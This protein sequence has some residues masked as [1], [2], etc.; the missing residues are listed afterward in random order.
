MPRASAKQ[1]I[2]QIYGMQS[3]QLLVNASFLFD[4]QNVI[5]LNPHFNSDQKRHQ[6][7]Y[8]IS[9]ICAIFFVDIFFV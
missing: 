1:N 3:F 9:Y 8:L 6:S 4:I 2:S 7:L 5:L